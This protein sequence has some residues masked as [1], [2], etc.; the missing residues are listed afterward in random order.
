MVNAF[1]AVS[2]QLL[3]FFRKDGS[4]TTAKDQYVTGI[5]LIQQV[6][7]VFEVLHVSAL[8][9]SH[10]NGLGVFLDCTVNDFVNTS[11]VTEVNN[12]AT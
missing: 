2:M 8:V 6:L 3:N 7:N 5:S 10:G 11:V 9:G 4:T 12:L 1:D